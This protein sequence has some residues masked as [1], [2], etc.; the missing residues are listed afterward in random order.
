MHH[1]MVFQKQATRFEERRQT[2]FRSVKEMCMSRSPREV[3]SNSENYLLVAL[4]LGLARVVSKN[5]RR[6]WG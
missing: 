1:K 4:V 3:T 6:T 5:G 2:L